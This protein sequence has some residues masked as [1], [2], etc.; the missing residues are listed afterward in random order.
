L[1][2]LYPSG[3]AEAEISGVR[4]GDLAIVAIPGEV[5]ARTGIKIKEISSL[6]NT[7]VAGYS[8]G[9]LRYISPQTRPLTREVMKRSFRYALLAGEL[10]RRS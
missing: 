10:R 8:N 5:F 7:I 6:A 2:K 4:I 9:G 1:R 3:I